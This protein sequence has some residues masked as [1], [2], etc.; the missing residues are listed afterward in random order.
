MKKPTFNFGEFK[1]LDKIFLTAENGV[2]VENVRS[3]AFDEETLYIAQ[4]DSHLE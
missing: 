1:Q 3:V 4:E 2:D